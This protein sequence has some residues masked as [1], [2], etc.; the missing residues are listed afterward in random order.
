MEVLEEEAFTEGL[1]PPAADLEC[2]VVVEDEG[3]AES[4]RSASK[5]NAVMLLLLFELF[6]LAVPAA[7]PPFLGGVCTE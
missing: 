5:S 4:S 7:A 3:A 6:A 1:P 2:V